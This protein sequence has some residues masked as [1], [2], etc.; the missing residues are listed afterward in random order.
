[1][2]NRILKILTVMC[3]T[4]GMFFVGEGSVVKAE[5][6]PGVEINNVGYVDAGK[7]IAAFDVYYNP[8]YDSSFLSAIGIDTSADGDVTPTDK[9]YSVVV[10]K[11]GNPDVIQSATTIAVSNYKNDGKFTVKFTVPEEVRADHDQGLTVSLSVNGFTPLSGDL[12]YGAARNIDP[13]NIGIEWNNMQEAGWELNISCS[14]E[15]CLAYLNSF[16]T[17]DNSVV[18]SDSKDS[19]GQSGKQ[20]DNTLLTVDE[21]AACLSAVWAGD[22]GI[23]LHNLFEGDN[24]LDPNQVKIS[25]NASGYSTVEKTFDNGS[26]GGGEEPQP[27]GNSMV[28]FGTKINGV[29]NS[30]NSD[31]VDFSIQCNKNNPACGAYLNK[32]KETGQF[33]IEDQSQSIQ[34]SF[35]GESGERSAFVGPTEQG[36]L[37]TV[38]LN[39]TNFPTDGKEWNFH[40]TRGKVIVSGYKELYQGDESSSYPPMGGCSISLSDSTTLTYTVQCEN[41]AFSDFSNN[42]TVSLD[43][44]REQDGVY[45][46]L[47]QGYQVSTDNKTLTFNRQNL[48]DSAERIEEDDYFVVLKVSRMNDRTYP[49]KR[50]DLTGNTAIHFPDINNNPMPNG[51]KVE[52]NN[53]YKDEQLVGTG[54][55]FSC[56]TSN[57]SNAKACDAFLNK[58]YNEASSGFKPGS[59][60]FDKNSG[61]ELYRT[62]SPAPNYFPI[63][64]QIFT[65]VTQQFEED[66]KTVT[67]TIA[68]VVSSEEIVSRGIP[69]GS[70]F[71]RGTAGAVGFGKTNMEPFASGEPVTITKGANIIEDVVY[72]QNDNNELTIT[73]SNED[74]L[75][76]ITNI[77]IDSKTTQKAGFEVTDDMRSITGPSVDGKYTMTLPLKETYY[78]YSIVQTGE[79]T[80]TSTGGSNYASGSI[81]LQ[82][83]FKSMPTDVRI[84]VIGDGL[85][86]T[87]TGVEKPEFLRTIANGPDIPLLEENNTRINFI[88]ENSN[89]KFYVARSSFPYNYKNG[90][91]TVSVTWDDLLA[92]GVNKDTDYLF[93]LNDTYYGKALKQ[94]FSLPLNPILLTYYAKNPQIYTPEQLADFDNLAVTSDDGGLKNVTVIEDPDNINNAHVDVNGEIAGALTTNNS[95]G[96]DNSDLNYDNP[97]VAITVT[98]DITNISAAEANRVASNYTT[99][100]PTNVAFDVAINKSYNAE[101]GKEGTVA[102]KELPYEASMKFKL[103]EEKLSEGEY[104]HL[105]TEHE[106]KITEIPFETTEEGMGIGYSKQFSEFVLVVGPKDLTPVP[107]P[108]PSKKESSSGSSTTKKTDN[109][110]TCQMAGYPASYAWN[111]SAKAC[112]PGY[113]DNIGVFHLTAGNANKRV[114][115]VNT[116]DKGLGGIIAG[117]ASSTVVAIATAYLLKKYN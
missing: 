26:G 113:I 77:E 70:V 92:L 3:L 104:Y 37:L 55:K 99:A 1:M 82:H 24:A 53:E 103:P 73:S 79:K 76:N 114:S 66:E 80:I 41:E 56:D 38:S 34:V 98:T 72:G 65:K 110:V 57:V 21:E 63:S 12:A 52:A 20:V 31:F 25:L 10:T 32:F 86:I 87:N 89:T 115:V 40:A 50:F 105:I 49:G 60:Y 11:S 109:V 59:G 69:S 9:S 7:T 94:D 96:S 78:V 68:L 97:D 39:K 29:V 47:G 30:E 101:S 90:G 74:F 61:F 13:Y 116:S 84:S 62:N 54:L 33:V 106:G 35:P 112:Q 8:D 93:Q 117:L 81:N 36:D 111:E 107:T 67:R 108:A 4:I 64:G 23:G 16:T 75:K 6:T 19:S 85:L 71:N 48:E 2:I 17:V 18:F 91:V 58:V 45:V 102:I 83:Q 43:L 14:G 27:S 15:T 95:G 5:E 42:T 46:N 28:P 22:N 51:L 100:T 44:S 88:D